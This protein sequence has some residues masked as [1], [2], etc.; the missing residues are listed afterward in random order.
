MHVICLQLALLLAWGDSTVPGSMAWHG[1]GVWLDTQGPTGN[2][3]QA[4]HG[5]AQRI[6][7]NQK[8]QC[9]V[10]HSTHSTAQ[11]T[12]PKVTVLRQLHHENFLDFLRPCDMWRRVGIEHGVKVWSN[13]A[14]HTLR[15]VPWAAQ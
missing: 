6:A 1:S 14:A 4:P 12:H 8:L 15:Y 9:T 10:Q 11:Q 7:Q 13:P 5:L 2:R 3:A